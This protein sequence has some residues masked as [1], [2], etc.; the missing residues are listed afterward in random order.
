MT[1]GNNRFTLTAVVVDELRPD[2]LSGGTAIKVGDRTLHV[3]DAK[4]MPVVTYVDEYMMGYVFASERL[5]AQE[6]LELVVSTD[7][8]TRA[9]EGR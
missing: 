7:L 4:G 1:S 5:N 8:M 6:L 3:H 2:D 9:Q